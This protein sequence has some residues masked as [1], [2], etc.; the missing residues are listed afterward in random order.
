MSTRIKCFCNVD[1]CI[2]KAKAKYESH[3]NKKYNYCTTNKFCVA[4]YNIK[5]N[6]YS[7]RCYSSRDPECDTNTFK[8]TNQTD[9]KT[10]D[11]CC[12]DT[13]LCNQRFTDYISAL[14]N[15][16]YY[17]K[18]DYHEVK[19]FLLIS[20]LAIA[21]FFLFIASYYYLCKLLIENKKISPDENEFK[22][23]IE[24]GEKEEDESNL[25][26]QRSEHDGSFTTKNTNSTA[27]SSDY[28]KNSIN[29]DVGEWSGSG[30]GS[31]A[32]LC[33]QSTISRQIK[34]FYPAIGKGRFGEVYKAE[35]RGE[36]VAVKSFS[37]SD[38]KSWENECRIYNLTG[39]RHENILG[40]ISADNI[41]RGNCVESW[42]ITDFH[43]HGSLYEYLIINSLA[44]KDAFKMAL[45]IVN[46]L[47]HLH[48]P[49]EG[50]FKKPAI[51][52]CDLK[53]RNILV[54][55]N[56]TCCIADFG[57]ALHADDYGKVVKTSAEIRT[58]TKRYMAPEI[59]SKTIN[60]EYLEAF[61]KAEMYS[62]GL[63]FWEL[64]RKCIIVNKTTNM[65]EKNEYKPP[66]YEFI[67]VDDPDE[68]L[69]KNIVCDNKCRPVF[70]SAWKEIPIMN[71]LAKLAQDLLVETPN[72]R[73]NS[74]RLK[75]SMNKI[76]NFY[77]NSSFD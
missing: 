58:G 44:P 42:L 2:F 26:S 62:L 49:V 25:N 47:S 48:L 46:G 60:K 6:N 77:I 51:A 35:W 17:D 16:I 45:S 18:N 66:Y 63:I 7:Y 27:I 56:G 24:K 53:S 57:L 65:N 22:L 23:I 39:F 28:K 59:I 74:F 19:K 31:G 38:H 67:L 75:K 61:K 3:N 33:V 52:H 36:F 73:L 1:S 72:E 68:D 64:L 20:L 50:T 70:S 43:Q 5:L 14:N 11:F 54:K 37:S 13:H 40:F 32:P 10:I 21:I 55:N 76:K 12:N 30:S 29:L 41:D 15:N 8:L 9:T 69:M 34:L 71:E 4:N